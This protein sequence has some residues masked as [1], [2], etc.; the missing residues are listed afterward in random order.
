MF[1]YTDI[2][3][4]LFHPKISYLFEGLLKVI[5][6]LYK[7]LFA[8]YVFLFN[9]LFC[10]RNNKYVSNNK[11]LFACCDPRNPDQTSTLGGRSLVETPTKR[12]HPQCRNFDHT[13]TK[14]RPPVS[15]FGRISD[16]SSTPQSKFAL[17]EMGEGKEGRGDEETKV[18]TAPMVYP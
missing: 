14:L 1:K 6:F 12:R 18:C 11:L 8:I 7:A 17:G 16:Q 3:N 4:K 10:T 2:W 9:K 13:S 5:H 15:K